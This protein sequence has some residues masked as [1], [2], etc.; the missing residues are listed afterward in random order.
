MCQKAE[1]SS[2]FLVDDRLCRW[3]SSSWGRGH[4]ADYFRPAWK[5]SADAEKWRGA[6]A[7]AIHA[8]QVEVATPLDTDAFIEAH[9]CSC[10]QVL[11]LCCSNVGRAAT[12]ELEAVSEYWWM[13]D[14]II[15]P[16]FNLRPRNQNLPSPP[17]FCKNLDEESF[18]EWGSL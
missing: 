1:F 14:E 9:K 5:S 8:L 4:S 6:A 3:E 10:G 7:A 17:W 11:D 18:N 15:D 13:D 12:E 2:C 16:F